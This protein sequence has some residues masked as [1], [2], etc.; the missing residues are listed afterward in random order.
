[1]ADS[2]FQLEPI[3]NDVLASDAEIRN[4]ADAAGLDVENLREVILKRQAEVWEACLA[5]ENAV[6][7][8]ESQR[9]WLEDHYIWN[10]PLRQPGSRLFRAKRGFQ[11]VL[12]IGILVAI[13]GFLDRNLDWPLPSGLLQFGLGLTA[14]GGVMSLQFAVLGRL[15]LRRRERVQERELK[16]LQT[17]LQTANELLEQALREKGIRGLL[18]EVINVQDPTYSHTF[19]VGK[20]A[21]LAELR[22]PLYEIRTKAKERIEN[23]LATMPGGSIG[24]SGPRGVGK[25]TLLRYFC[26][27]RF[28]RQA[29]GDRPDLR[30]LISAPVQYDAREFVLY[31]FSAICQEVLGPEEAAD[32]MRRGWQRHQQRRLPEPL[33]LALWIGGP[34]AVLLALYGILQLLSVVFNW[35]LNPSIASGVLLLVIGLGALATLARMTLRRVEGVTTIL[36]GLVAWSPLYLPGQ[37][38]EATE[39]LRKIAREL[40]L[41]LTYQQTFTHGWTGAIKIPVGLEGGISSTTTMMDRPVSYPEVVAHFSDFL[42]QVSVSHRILIGIDEMDKIDSD[43]LANHFLNDLK[44]V[45]GLENCFWLVSVSQSAMSAFERRGMPFRDVFDSS[46]DVIVEVDYLDL[47]A[48]KLLL[49]RRA[50]GMSVP[51]LCLCHC[52]SG[53]LPRDL[54]RNARELLELS[55]APEGS[56]EL[57]NLTRTL[58]ASELDRKRRAVAIAAAKISA[59]PW[60]GRFLDAVQATRADVTPEALLNASYALVQDGEHDP[61]DEAAE[62]HS[63]LA[64][65]RLELAAY[66][67]YCATLTRFFSND[68]TEARLKAAEE[69]TGDASIDQLARA[70]QAFA[71]SPR[72]A[73]STVSTFRGAYDPTYDMN[74]LPLMDQPDKTAARVALTPD[75]NQTST[76]TPPAVSS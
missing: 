20:A 5:E 53:G 68:L 32:T 72:V 25:T 69:A 12:G 36:G 57:T 76:P 34:L 44:A 56:N 55:R 64:L 47:A 37:W 7:A 23:L 2:R 74:V 63:R 21:G 38:D 52:L 61:Q 48:S 50:I 70:R 16:A 54:I 1:M 9:Q 3:L 29:D 33:Y 51:F 22:D 17:Q 31:L 58:V 60:T 26:S 11:V 8:L 10:V 28:A 27:P 67:Y 42:K 30:V 19:Q 35:K 66:H 39:R 73:W 43:E 14:L 46:F 18:R 40:L 59:E 41:G 75:S 45:F 49:Q 71:V 62:T 65:L 4:A 13:I 15:S 6:R 24:I